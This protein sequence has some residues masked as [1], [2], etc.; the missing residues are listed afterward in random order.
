MAIEGPNRVD[1]ATTKRIETPA[2]NAASANNGIER[3]PVGGGA[4]K[5][6]DRD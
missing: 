5:A 1:P 2:A 3:V 4:L 6:I